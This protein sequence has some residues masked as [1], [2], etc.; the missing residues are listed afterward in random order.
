MIVSDVVFPHSF[1][2]DIEIVLFPSISEIAPEM[3]P[4]RALYENE[5]AAPFNFTKT[6]FWLD[7]FPTF[8]VNDVFPV[9]PTCSKGL[10]EGLIKLTVGS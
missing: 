7:T 2:A 1:V 5:I 9:F 3:F 8:A 10:V 4:E 6:I